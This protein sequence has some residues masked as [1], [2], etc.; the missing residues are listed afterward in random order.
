MPAI[1]I[2]ANN[3]FNSGWLAAFLGMPRQ[4]KGADAIKS[5]DLAAYQ[6]GWD[7]Q[8]ETGSDS[9]CL[10]AFRKMVT[11]GQITIDWSDD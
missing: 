9:A 7:M 1:E 5:G 2:D 4:P 8:K 10:M 6:D 11:L 3:S